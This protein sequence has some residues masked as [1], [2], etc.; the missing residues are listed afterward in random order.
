M[1]PFVR[2]T[3]RPLSL[4]PDTRLLKRADYQTFVMA[5]QILEAARRETEERQAERLRPRPA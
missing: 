1:D 2:L 4:A 5:G 3:D